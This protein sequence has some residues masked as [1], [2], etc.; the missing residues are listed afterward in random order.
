MA[1]SKTFINPHCTYN[2][3]NFYCAKCYYDKK[4]N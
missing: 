1:F 2:Q 3:L 4:F